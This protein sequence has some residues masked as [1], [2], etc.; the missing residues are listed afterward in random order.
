MLTS[1]ARPITARLLQFRLELRHVVGAVEAL[2][3][4]L[5]HLGR[6]TAA[7]VVEEPL[8]LVD[9]NSI[10]GCLQLLAGLRLLSRFEVRVLLDFPAVEA[11][12][13]QHE[14]AASQ[15]PLVLSRLL[16]AKYYMHFQQL[17]TA[18]ALVVA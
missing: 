16:Y 14:L 4:C 3:C 18:G 1:I 2:V 8:V 9:R 5:H 6:E 13:A 11:L 12:L 10:H 15:R 17:K 7:N